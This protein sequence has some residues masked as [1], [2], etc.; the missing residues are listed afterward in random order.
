MTIICQVDS[1][2]FLD[3]TG[4]SFCFSFLV[5]K[6]F[7]RACKKLTGLPPAMLCSFTLFVSL[8]V[9]IGPKNTTGGQ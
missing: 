2:H 5:G 1:D 6:F 9:Y 4:S 3:R 7:C 8:L